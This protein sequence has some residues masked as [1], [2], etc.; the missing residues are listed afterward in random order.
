MSKNYFKLY[1]VISSV[2]IITT[3]IISTP[4]LVYNI[5]QYNNP[6]MFIEDYDLSNFNSYENW[7]IYY[8]SPDVNKSND[9]IALKN[10]YNEYKELKL[11][12]IKNSSYKLI[13][14]FSTFDIL[15]IILFP[16]HLLIIIRNKDN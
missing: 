15:A 8:N 3:F 7:K 6:Q 4:F 9:E 13:V 16:L 11:R 14:I 1:G 5:T 10:K 12:E 2:I